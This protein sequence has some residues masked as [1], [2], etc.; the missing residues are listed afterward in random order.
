MDDMSTRISNDDDGA[1]REDRERVS[2][3]RREK[4]RGK[5][6]RKEQAS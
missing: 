1:I 6:R 5:R 3:G 2:K 4:K